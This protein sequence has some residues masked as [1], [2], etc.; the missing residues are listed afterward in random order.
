MQARFA[1][2]HPAI[3]QKTPTRKN[4]PVQNVN[5]AKTEPHYLT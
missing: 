1:A 5:D 3:A 2:K 4:D